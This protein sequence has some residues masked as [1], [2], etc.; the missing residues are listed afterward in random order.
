MRFL[1]PPPTVLLLLAALVAPATAATT[2]RPDWNRLRG[3][4]RARVEVSEQAPSLETTTP[5]ALQAHSL[6]ASVRS[7]SRNTPT[8]DCLPFL[9]K[10]TRTI[11]PQPQDAHLAA[12][13][14]KPLPCSPSGWTAGPQT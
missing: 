11:P 4:A 8:P 14:P 12:W 3:L 2:Y 1:L 13:H 10:G 9:P 7:G 5:A 6:E